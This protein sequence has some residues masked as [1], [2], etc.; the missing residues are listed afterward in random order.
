MS[1]SRREGSCASARASTQPRCL[2]AALVGFLVIAAAAVAAPETELIAGPSGVTNLE[3]ATFWWAG[4][5]DD[6]TAPI[7]GYRYSLDGAVPTFTT[8]PTAT[9]YDLADGEHTL[10]VAAV[11][12]D[13]AEDDTPAVAAFS[14]SGEF[15]VEVE[16]NNFDFVATPAVSGMPVRATS[17]DANDADWHVL[18]PEPGARQVTLTFRRPDAG[19][20]STV[21]RV[22]RDDPAFG[23]VVFDGVVSIATNHR[24]SA[25][26]GVDAVP[27]Y[28]FVQM[29]GAAQIGSQYTLT[30]TSHVPGA[31]QS[32][33]AFWDTEPNDA[34]AFATVIPASNETESLVVFGSTDAVG[35]EDWFRLS[36]DVSSTRL[37]RLTLARPGSRGSAVVEAFAGSLP[38]ADRQIALLTVNAANGQFATF[39]TAV[40]LGDVLVHVV[41]DDEPRETPYAL[42]MDLSTLLAG[43]AYEVEPNGVDPRVNSRSPNAL[44]LNSTVMGQSWAADGDVDWFRVDV[45]RAGVLSAALSRPAGLGVTTT[46]LYN[47]NFL[48]VGEAEA[49]AT[50]GQSAFLASIATA[51]FYYI[52]VSAQGESPHAAYSLSTELESPGVFSAEHTATGALTLGETLSV[53]LL[54]PPG[55]NASFS[56]GD[57][58]ANLP[59]FDDGAHEDGAADDGQYVGSYVVRST[60]ELLALDVVARVSDINGDSSE[61]VVGA[62]VTL[63]GRA[64]SPVAAVVAADA[65]DDNGGVLL[66]EWAASDASDLA[67]YLVYVEATP[68]VSASGLTPASRTT[69]TS[70]SVSVDASGVP[71][72]VAV[73]AVDRAGNESTMA[74]GSVVGPVAAEDNR[75]PSPVTQVVAENIPDDFGGVARVRWNPVFL[76]DFAEYRVYAAPDA[77]EDV[78]GLAPSAR[79]ANPFRTDVDVTGLPS[80][81]PVFF[82]VTVMDLTGNESALD[83]SSTTGPVTAT[84][85]AA[86]DAS[87]LEVVGPLGVVR[88]GSAHFQW[89]RFP[90][91]RAEAIGDVI[92][93][94]D[95]TNSRL[96]SGAST[97]FHG[98][99][100]GRHVA[101]FAESASG[102]ATTRVFHVDAYAPPEV[103]PNDISAL[104]ETLRPGEALTGV[105]ANDADWTRLDV[106]APGAAAITVTRHSGAVEARVYRQA[107]AAESLV[108]AASLDD[109]TPRVTLLVGVLAEPLL[110]E[111]RGDG[112]YELSYTW[113]WTPTFTVEREPNDTSSRAT[114]LAPGQ[115]APRVRGSIATPD[116]L[117]WFALPTFAAGN[118]AVRASAVGGV[119][120]LRVFRDEDQIGAL[121]VGDGEQFGDIFLRVD[122]STYSVAVDGE[123]GADYEIAIVP[124]ESSAPREFEPNGALAQATSLPL[125]SL[126]VGSAWGEADRDVYRIETPTSGTLVAAL[127]RRGAAATTTLRMLGASGAELS[128]SSMLALDEAT[129]TQSPIGPGTTFV[130]VDTEGGDPTEYELRVTLFDDLRHGA[131]G[132][133]KAGDQVGASLAWRPGAVGVVE[134]V[135]GSGAREVASLVDAE[136]AGAYAATWTVRDGEDGVDLFLR[137]RVTEGGQ[138]WLVTFPGSIT[139]DTT[140]PTILNASHDA[141]SALGVGSTLHVSASAEEGAFGSFTL[142]RADGAAARAAV[143]MQEADGG[144]Y[145]GELAIGAADHLVGGKVRVSFEDEVG[146]LATRDI[147]RRLT[148]DTLPPTVESVTHDA[149]GVLIEGDTITV[150]A[151]G[152]ASAHGSFAILVD[153]DT[154]FREDIPLFDDGAH[155]DGD[156]DD[157]VYRGEYTTRL[158]DIAL[159]AVVRARLMDDAGNEAFGLA[160]ATVSIDASTPTIESATHSAAQPLALGDTL[161]I[162]V[163]GSPGETGSFAI[164]RADGT[165]YRADLRLVEGDSDG[166]YAGLFDVGVGNDLVGGVVVVTLLKANGKSVTRS[167][168]A[169]VTFDTTPPAAVLGVRARDVEGDEGG[170]IALSWDATSASDFARYEVYRSTTPLATTDGLVPEDIHLPNP[171]VDSL[172]LATDVGAAYYYAVV[173]VDEAGNASGLSLDIG[174]SVSPRVEALDNLPPPPVRNVLAI[175]RPNDGG[176]VLSVVWEPTP[177]RDFAEYRVY[178]SPEPFAQGAPPLGVPVVRAPAPWVTL[179]DVPAP[180]DGAELYVTVSVADTSGNESAVGATGVSGPVVSAADGAPLPGGA[181]SVFGGPTGVARHASSAFRWNRFSPDGIAIPNYLFS[182]DGGPE[183]FTSA[184]EALFAGLTSGEHVFSVT[185]ADGSA[186]VATRRFHVDPV[187]LPEREPNDSPEVAMPLPPGVAVDGVL[188]DESDI[189]RYRLQLSAP[190]QVALH[191]TRARAG[192]ARMAL[193]SLSVASESGE[194]ASV[195][196][197]GLERPNAHTAM[198]LEAGEY[199][200]RITG[201]AGP[202]RAV[203]A[204]HPTSANIAWDTE[205]NDDP[206]RATRVFGEAIEISGSANREGDVDWYRVPVPADGFPIIDLSLAQ[207]ASQDVSLVE[208]FHDATGL[209]PVSL[210]AVTLTPDAPSVMLRSGVRQGDILL[211][212]SPAAGAV[213]GARVAF[214]PLPPD[215]LVE[216]EPNGDVAVASAVAPGARVDGSLWG[217]GDTDWYRME[218]VPSQDGLV[219]LTVE[220]AEPRAV[221]VAEAFTVGLESLGAFLPSSSV[222]NSYGL[223]V[224]SSARSFFVRVRGEATAYGLVALELSSAQHDA[225]APLGSG[226]ELVV[227]VRGEDGWDARAEIAGHGIAFALDPTT[228]GTYVGTYV[229]EP[230]RDV[231]DATVIVAIDSPTGLSV[232][233]PLTP[234]ITL[235]TVPPT[236]SDAWHSGGRPLRADEDLRI[237]AT[238]ERGSRVSYEVS[239]AASGGVFRVLG[240]LFDDGQHDDGDDSDGLYAGAYRVQPGD[241]AADAIVSVTAT[242]SVGNERSVAAP[243]PVD[244]DTTPPLI[245]QVSHDGASVLREGDR[246]VVTAHGEAGARGAFSVEGVRDGLPLVDDGTRSDQTAGDGI[247]VGSTLILAGDNATG[248]IVSVALTDTAGNVATAYAALPV[249]IDTSAP[250][251]DAVTH[252]ATG[253]LREGDRL[254]VRVSGEAGGTATFDIAAA[255][256]GIAMFDDGAGDDDDANDGVY[257]GAY[258]VQPGDDLAEAIITARVTDRNGNVGFRAATSRVT[259]DAVPPPSVHDLAVEDSPGDQGNRLRVSWTA[260]EGASDFLRYHIYRETAPIRSTRGLT[261]VSAEIVSVAREATEVD[262]PTNNVDYYFGIAAVDVARNEGELSADGASAFGPVR[263]TDDLSPASVLGVTATDAPDDDGGFVVVSWTSQSDETDFG[264]Y[265]VFLDTDRASLNDLTGLQADLVEADRTVTQVLAPTTDDV[266]RFYVAVV[267]RDINGN[268]SAVTDASSAGPVASTDDTA[269]LP[270]AGVHVADAPG[271]EGGRLSV[272]WDIPSDPTVVEFE[273]YLSAAAIRSSD[274]LAGIDPVVS[275]QTPED[276]TKVSTGVIAPTP[277]DDAEWHVAVAAVDGGG[278]RSDIAGESVDG[279]VRSV[280][281]VLTST[282]SALIQAG[283]DP[284]TSVRIPASVA[285]PGVRIDIY[286]T[287][288]ATLQRSADEA[289]LNLAVANIDD[290]TEADLRVSLRHIDANPTKFPEPL[291]VTVSF[292]PPDSSEVARDLR[293]FRL[294]TA[295]VPA[296]WDLVSGEQTVDTGQGVVSARSATMGVLRVARLLLPRQL[297]RVTVAPNPFRPDHDGVVTLRNLTEGSEV[298]IFTLDAHRVARLVNNASGMATWDGRNDGGAPVA[299]GLYLYLIRAPN[300]RR[301]GQILVIR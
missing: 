42:L 206:R 8:Q 31:N 82:A 32:A 209:E 26:F 27:Y 122:A 123:P 153:G 183:R 110:I 119:A 163:V 72:F 70:A 187:S 51:G 271:D 25:T 49:T 152:D 193:V 216:V 255:R 60:D 301:V 79:I 17:S 105:V 295:A 239:D 10:S 129:E 205:P 221:V 50:N 116:E 106:P 90:E 259:L 224:A 15:R 34:D 182:L 283:F 278:N 226:G 19:V 196:A 286:D 59:M 114:T 46:R 269:P 149:D 231:R 80:E 101:R 28:A 220:A 300:D 249:S 189:D 93:T 14:V 191:L 57:A 30:M 29:D 67:Q 71:L 55:V 180:V 62:P 94:L 65:P 45:D 200:V 89:A 139:I 145:G 288:D 22:Y 274:D 184:N 299:S 127:S 115:V 128:A 133:L 35:D 248:S 287:L 194:L 225:R 186:P 172:V 292:P 9:F 257:T 126:V 179:A 77:V 107:G 135:N 146:N 190:A 48:L 210:G 7:A 11:G 21:V 244:L 150:T 100:P 151:R 222:T 173:T 208:F 270:V 20:G 102:V 267:A 142:L 6:P 240:D 117:D 169:P 162:T 83:A 258:V 43:D 253:P 260:V 161:H 13:L 156:A 109:A 188:L 291:V 41:H 44:A 227:S 24:L 118:I 245:E 297:S 168:A 246:L 64:P 38:D 73:T 130:A 56:V 166:Q 296:R 69:A 136:G 289:N 88:G 280:A 121:T 198:A 159:G 218:V 235:D 141:R 242:D 53:S 285:R 3:D 294:N 275:S 170:F 68:V 290:A 265:A 212:V 158:G 215:M 185:P 54:A 213:Y 99:A 238:A 75:L 78:S 214:S 241:A 202:Y 138:T 298:E 154:P 81:A 132:T 284:Q 223:A 232:R 181:F 201:D 247:Y 2:L 92:V 263:A 113:E 33:A 171:T 251:L 203:V 167:L 40:G 125:D 157:G 281:N 97:T 266:Q 230:G 131:A 207:S 276:D 39:E 262:V 236:I 147:S 95:G 160:S 195:V 12:I 104:A 277:K 140:P 1:G 37:L 176:G 243:R 164:E 98:L 268:Y 103:E 84:T 165:T 175:D 178:V 111:M 148:I 250:E 219:A 211:K 137:A 155:D 272:T 66:V 52:K 256:Q 273:V 18:A 144:Q 58:R 264:G 261:P 229:V 279:P 293:L 234:T 74:P 87:L 204:A 233:V 96:V 85:E 177:A 228:P 36:L 217:E 5:S 120:R 237:S 254:V 197:D 192:V 47:S 86:P 63:D 91:G 174:G 199:L 4:V 76:P 108:H 252:S 61:R 282:D 112:A 23:N 143:P 16:P 134:L 124:G